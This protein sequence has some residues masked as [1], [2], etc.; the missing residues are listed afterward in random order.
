MILIPTRIQTIYGSDSNSDSK[1]D[2]DHMIP[3]WENMIQI[4]IPTLIRII[5]DFFIRLL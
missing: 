2:Y 1:S 4:L 3:I 5:C